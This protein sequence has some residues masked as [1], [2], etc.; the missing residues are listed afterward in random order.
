MTYGGLLKMPCRCSEL[1]PELCNYHEIGINPSNKSTNYSGL[2]NMTNYQLNK[3]SYQ[4]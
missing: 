2:E 3:S 4:K 1:G